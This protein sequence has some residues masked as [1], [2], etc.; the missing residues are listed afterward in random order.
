MAP[1]LDVGSVFERIF[2]MYRAQAGLLLPA[3]LLLFLPPALLLVL[4]A[5]LELPILVLVSL[6]AVFVAQFWYGGVVVEAVRD[7]LDGRRDLTLE[8]LLGSATPV[9]GPLVGAG[10]LAGIGIGLGLIALIVPGLYL[11]TIWALIAPVLVVERTGIRAAFG[12]SRDLVR[13]N[14]WRVFAVVIVLALLQGIVSNLLQVA[15]E[16]VGG[17]VAVGVGQLVGTVLLAPL[18]A[19][20]ASVMYFRLV[21]TDREQPAPQASPTSWGPPSPPPDRAT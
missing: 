11:L 16:A 10:L 13:G 19:L 9:I 15:G 1:H 12:R 17:D 7:M 3:A 20:A 2:A 4:A 6:V 21:G 14:G 8:R 5:V 18:G